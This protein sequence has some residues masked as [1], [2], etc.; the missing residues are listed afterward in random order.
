MPKKLILFRHAKSDWTSGAASDHARP[1]ARRGMEAARV[2]GKFLMS[3]GEVP[4]QILCSSAVRAVATTQLAAKAGG[5]IIPVDFRDSLYLPET[6]SVIEEIR[7]APDKLSSL[8]LVGHEPTWSELASL[9]IGD[10][11]I[12]VS[13]G[14]MLRID[15]EATRWSEVKPGSGQLRWLIPP[16]LLGRA[17]RR[18]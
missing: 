12:K 3:A 11:R 18:S 4:E 15:F 17:I 5:W 6:G 2:M 16:K 13:T 9:L 7:K 1:L 10:A 8:M 14:S